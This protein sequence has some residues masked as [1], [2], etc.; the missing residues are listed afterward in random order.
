MSLC[1][2]FN[3]S[4]NFLTIKT[5]ERTKYKLYFNNTHPHYNYELNTKTATN[6][7]NIYFELI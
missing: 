4:S 7:I 1:N 5:K 2:F 3:L 6:V